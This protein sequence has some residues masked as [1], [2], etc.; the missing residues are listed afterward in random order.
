MLVFV[1]PGGFVAISLFVAV[2][3]LTSQPLA[4]TLSLRASRSL[5]IFLVIA[6]QTF[7]AMRMF[8][9]PWGSPLAEVF[10]Y[11]RWVAFD[12]HQFRLPCVEGIGPD[13]L[14]NYIIALG[15]FPAFVVT[16]LL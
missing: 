5:L 1:V 6:L 13:P 11:T 4:E 8:D 15:V 10:S 14:T 7:Q 2:R 12:M 16:Y 3:A 9:I